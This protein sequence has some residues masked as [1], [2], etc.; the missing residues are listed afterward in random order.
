[1]GGGEVRRGDMGGHQPDLTTFQ[2]ETHETKKKKVKKAKKPKE[3]GVLEGAHTQKK[4]VSKLL[5]PKKEGKNK[6]N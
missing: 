6:K 3:G 4:N 2:Q 5:H 1:M